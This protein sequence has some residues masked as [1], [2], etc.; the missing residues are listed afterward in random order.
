MI[1]I[2]DAF[3]VVITIFIV[4]ATCGLIF[5]LFLLIRRI[6]RKRKEESDV[7]V[8]DFI[9][10]NEMKSVVETYIERDREERYS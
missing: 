5:G 8:E 6:E 9:P 3:S 2:T 1:L 10:K 7:L 4:L